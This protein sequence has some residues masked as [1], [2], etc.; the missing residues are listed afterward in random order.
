MSI[1]DDDKIWIIEQLA[2]T[3]AK[4]ERVETTLLTEFHTAK[5]SAPR[6]QRAGPT[7]LTLSG[8]I[9]TLGIDKGRPCLHRPYA[10]KS[11]I[12]D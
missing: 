7:V 4:I 8:R 2:A 12:F 5:R 3:N 10:A 1:S 11:S 9:A 6:Q